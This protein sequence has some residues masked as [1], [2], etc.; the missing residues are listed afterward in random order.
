MA[1]WVFACLSKSGGGEE[2]SLLLSCM[3]PP[4]RS[5]LPLPLATQTAAKLVTPRPAPVVTK[6]PVLLRVDTTSTKLPPLDLFDGVGYIPPA[7]WA[8]VP[9]SASLVTTP[10]AETSDMTGLLTPGTS[11][12]FDAWLPW[13]MVNPGRVM[14]SSSSRTNSSDPWK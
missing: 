5:S 2:R 13:E 6:N 12:P 1:D 14:S 7:Y 3:S 11:N 8:S 9:E 10:V 4:R